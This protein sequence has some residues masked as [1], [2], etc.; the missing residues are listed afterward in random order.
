MEN[1]TRTMCT[2][3]VIIACSMLFAFTQPS[4]ALDTSTHKALN[5]YI[6]QQSLNGFSL[7]DYLK[8]QLG[9]E[10]GT[11]AYFKNSELNQQVFRWVGDGGAFEDNPP[12]CFIPYMRSRHHFHNPI[13]NSGFSGIS[14]TGI[15][16][17]MSATDWAMQP[18]GSQSCGCYSWN[19]ARD[20]YYKA[21]TSADKAT[22]EA[23]FAATFR[24]VGQ[25]MHLVQD[26]REV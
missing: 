13:D 18:V 2:I 5:E 26:I 11:E 4:F 15:L 3:L 17:G 10:D 20:Y 24:A 23:N 6:V 25:V 14:D 19:D 12:E 7:N 16:S 22:R 1:K 9:I 8:T 21:L